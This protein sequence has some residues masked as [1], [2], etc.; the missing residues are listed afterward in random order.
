MNCEEINKPLQKWK[1][2]V[3]SVFWILFCLPLLYGESQNSA[4]VDGFEQNLRDAY[5][6]GDSLQKSRVYRQIGMEYMHYSQFDMALEN[7]HKALFYAEAL[8][9]QRAIAT[10]GNSLAECYSKQGNHTKAL[11]VYSRSAE[12]FTQMSDSLALAT[13]LGNIACELQE[14][15][16][17]SEAVKINLQAIRIKENLG[18]SA[19]LAFFYNK[20]AE[21]H[22]EKN[23]EKHRQWL[24]NAW[25]LSQNPDYTSFSA[26]ISIY[27]NLGKMYMDRGLTDMA[28]LFYDSLYQLSADQFYQEGM[29]VGLSN[30]ALVF[31]RKGNSPKALEYHKRAL[32]LS[33]KGQNVYRRTGHFINAGKLAGLL[34]NDHEAV[35]L[36]QKGLELATRY[37][38]PQYRKEAFEALK[39]VYRRQSRWH[40]AFTA[41]E[42]YVNVRD[43]LEGL[44]VKEK[45]LELEEQYK[46]QKKVRQIELLMA[47][48]QWNVKRRKLLTALLLTSLFLLFSIS[49]IIRLRH[50][51]LQQQNELALKGKE[52]YRLNQEN[53]QLRLDQKNR[54]LSSLALQVAQKAEFLSDLKEQLAHTE[55]DRIKSHI[56]QIDNL[57]KGNGYWESFRLHFQEVHPDFFRKLKTRFPDLTPNEE[58]LCAFLKMNLT[59]KEIALINN[60]TTAAV[61]KSRNRLRKKLGVLPEHNLKDFLETV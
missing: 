33:E 19:S 56:M 58:R 22:E 41:F 26:N 50:R 18:D 20:M 11:E 24:M 15:G 57:I 1:K 48:N 34:G 17:R 8:E 44:A 16:R 49:F 29:E 7:L 12:I 9:H 23:P 43:S 52:I 53:L 6:Q 42:N 13:I 5:E 60:N 35:N 30:K 21:L 4:I 61:D 39:E 31:A 38:Y 37:H 36:L 40:E 28:L 3:V 14:M 59:T 2:W 10:I 55:P 25:E 47:Q 54:E 51:K 45:V 27:N 32:E 46:N